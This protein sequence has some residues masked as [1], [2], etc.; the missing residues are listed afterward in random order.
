MNTLRDIYQKL[1][2]RANSNEMTRC[3]MCGHT[4][5]L[6]E[7]QQH[8]CGKYMTANDVLIEFLLNEDSI[9]FKTLNTIITKLRLLDE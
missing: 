9:S 4:T 5:N 2:I 3:W 1:K 7:S 6:G 8:C